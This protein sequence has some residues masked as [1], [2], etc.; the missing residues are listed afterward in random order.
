[1]KKKILGRFYLGFPLGIAI[2]FV[3]TIFISI[4]LGDGAYYPCTPQFLEEM[5]TP[6]HAVILQTV[7]CGILGSISCAGSVVWQLDRWS[8]LKQSGVYFAILSTAMMPIAYVLYWMEHSWIGAVSY[9]L[10]FAL[11]FVFV[12]IFQYVVWKIKLKKM[13]QKLN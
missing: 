7:L 2:G 5:K 8:I 6:L 13:N 3:I 1:M 10:V 12:W 9:F 4:G 11:I